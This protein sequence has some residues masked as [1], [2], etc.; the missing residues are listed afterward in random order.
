MNDLANV[1]GRPGGAV[2]ADI[3]A[4]NGPFVRQ[5]EMPATEAESL[6][7]TVPDLLVDLWRI[8]GLGEIM[9]GR[10]RLVQPSRFR[11]LVR[12]MLEG[13]PDFG[14]G[15][16]V[17]AHTAFGDLIL[18]H[19]RHQFIYISVNQLF[20]F[21]PHLFRPAPRDLADE[22]LIE[23]LLQA[24]PVI[25]DAHDLQ[26]QPL[27]DAAKTAFGLPEPPAV[28]GFIPLTFD[29]AGRTLETIR[30]VQP[31]DYAG[32]LL[33]MGALTLQDFE[34]QQLNIRTVGRQP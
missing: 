21:A 5:D 17:I 33:S 4:L 14:T 16:H 12:F 27:F 28:Y 29:P 6:I 18:W 8:H 24:D 3:M 31:A 22:I 15:C 19:A 34:A 26:G 20:V 2:L 1:G 13:D 32:E 23:R 7:G 10:I 30:M 9:G 25:F 11:G